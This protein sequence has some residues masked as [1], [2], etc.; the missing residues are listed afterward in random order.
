MT[1]ADLISTI[2]AALTKKNPDLSKRMISDIVDCCFENLG[3]GIK[4]D[5]RFSFPGFGTWT[6]KMRKARQG[7]NPQ[8]GQPITIKATKTC[9]F[10]PSIE[11]KRDINK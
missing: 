9:T 2:H 11:F 5:K 4:K 7:V 8:T 3:R 6:V 1:K 10:K